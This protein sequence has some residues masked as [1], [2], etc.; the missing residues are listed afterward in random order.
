MCTCQYYDIFY[1]QDS[2]LQKFWLWLM[3]ANEALKNLPF[4]YVTDAELDNLFGEKIGSG[5]SDVF[6][7]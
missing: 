7:K 5:R 6:W 2:N 4:Y 1:T 3:A